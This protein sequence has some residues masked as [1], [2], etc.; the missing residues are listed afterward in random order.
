MFEEKK[1]KR[2]KNIRK[3]IRS[4]LTDRKDLKNNGISYC[5]FQK[6]CSSKFKYKNIANKTKQSVL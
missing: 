2:E 6:P 5:R 3:T 1:R 4:F